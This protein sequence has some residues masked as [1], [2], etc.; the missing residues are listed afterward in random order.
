MIVIGDENITQPAGEITT[1][2]TAPAT[3]ATS[4]PTSSRT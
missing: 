2:T 1:S 3:M 4:R